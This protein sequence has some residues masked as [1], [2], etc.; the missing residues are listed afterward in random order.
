M[1]PAKDL[2]FTHP[3]DRDGQIRISLSQ[4]LMHNRRTGRDCKIIGGGTSGIWKNIIAERGL[5]L[6]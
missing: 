3:F 6:P 1:P 2:I 4:L 5:G